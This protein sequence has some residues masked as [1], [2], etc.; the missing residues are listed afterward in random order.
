MDATSEWLWVEKQVTFHNIQ[1]CWRNSSQDCK[2]MSR[3]LLEPGIRESWQ[4]SCHS[5]LLLFA[6]VLCCF[7]SIFFTWFSPLPLASWWNACPN[8]YWV[9]M[10]TYSHLR[11]LFLST[12]LNDLLYSFGHFSTWL[13]VTEAPRWTLD[14][15]IREG[16]SEKG[17]EV[18]WQTFHKE[19][20]T[21]ES[22]ELYS[23]KESQGIVIIRWCRALWNV[24][25]C[26]M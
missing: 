17:R 23:I 21:S 10:P 19:C 3:N 9:S 14:L 8:T 15:R 26:N 16:F 1:G 24:T 12:V 18:T 5:S 22:P 11:I 20:A 6:H 25:E 2:Q 13:L 4:N 7:L